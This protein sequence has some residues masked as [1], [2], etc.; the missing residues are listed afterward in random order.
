MIQQ[1]TMDIKLT[2][3]YKWCMP[4]ALLHVSLSESFDPRTAC[5]A[6]FTFIDLCWWN[7]H[8]LYVVGIFLLV[9]VKSIRSC[10]HC[11]GSSN[12][13]CIDVILLFTWTLCGHRP[14][15]YFLFRYDNTFWYF[16]TLEHLN[17]SSYFN[18]YMRFVGKPEYTENRTSMFNL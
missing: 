10:F 12:M 9:R 1:I 17:G 16:H 5:G 14:V 18:P 2:Q 15:G 4:P 7:E 6:V 3:A 11:M 13:S 8:H